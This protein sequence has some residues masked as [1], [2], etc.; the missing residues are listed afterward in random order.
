MSTLGLGGNQEKPIGLSMRPCS[1]LVSC[2]PVSIPSINRCAGLATHALAAPL[3]PCR[4]CTPAATWLAACLPGRLQPACHHRV[5]FFTSP[6]RVGA[7]RR[8]CSAAQRPAPQ[9]IFTV[10]SHQR[11]LLLLL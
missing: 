2:D 9:W 5:S 11:P 8:R 10:A 3:Y 4:A 1:P 7:M 6:P